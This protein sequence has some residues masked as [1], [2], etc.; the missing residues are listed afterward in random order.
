M[1]RFVDLRHVADDI[2]GDRFAFY[3]TVT[4]TFVADDMGAQTWETIGDF[5]RGYQ[6]DELGRFVDLSPE[7][8]KHAAPER[9]IFKVEVHREPKTLPVASATN[10]S[11][12][13][14]CKVPLAPVVLEAL[15]GRE[16][17][18]FYGVEAYGFDD[19]IGAIVGSIVI[20]FEADAGDQPW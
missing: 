6:G 3:D 19:E 10:K 8:A 5:A 2:G 14:C 17:A 18:Y 12:S 7:W 15:A 4:D 20:D 1:I 13:A 11:G 9:E 16:V